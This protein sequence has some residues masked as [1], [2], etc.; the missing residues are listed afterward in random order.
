MAEFQE[1]FV[2]SGEVKIHYY[3]TGGEHAPLVLVHGIT[4]DGACWTRVAR[5]LAADYDVIMMDLRGHGLSDAPANG[6]SIDRMAEDLAALITQLKL[7]KP[8]VLGHS[9]GGIITLT[10]AAL[11][12]ELPARIVLEDPAPFWVHDSPPPRDSQFRKGLPGWISRLQGKT[13]AELMEE[14]R[15]SNPNWDEAEYEPWVRSKMRV[16]PN[17]AQMS[18]MDDTVPPGYKA[19]LK[20][21]SCPVLFL[22]SDPALGA[23]CR[24]EEITVLR[25]LVPQVTT[26]YIAN[27]GHN[28]H[29]DQYPAFQAAIRP[30][31]TLG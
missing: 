1:G 6:Y 17:V 8:L 26:S 11:H 13:Y 29:R 7:E 22:K 23:I 3:R 28:I 12:P 16:S 25:G 5:D 21:V 20:K 9:L 27:A 15:G 10:L 2:Q 30:F 24:E 14:I 4:D 31:F 18:L 19:M